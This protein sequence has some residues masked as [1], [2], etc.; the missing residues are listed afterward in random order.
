MMRN[1]SSSLD[2]S[3][4]AARG[5]L[6]ALFRTFD[7]LTPDE[8]ARI[9]YR[10][11]P[12]D[13]RD[14][15]LDAV[16]EAAERTGRVVLVGEARDAAREAVMMRYSAG[17]LHPTFVGLNWGISQGT[18][19]TRVAIAETLADA[20]AAA[21]VADALDPE[22]TDALANDAASIADLAVG[23][24][25]DGSLARALRDPEDSDLRLGP[26]ARRLRLVGAAVMVVASAVASGIG[27]MGAAAV[28]V[29]AGVRALTRGGRRER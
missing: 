15:L 28:G 14:P 27:A 23:E 18:I 24:V 2:P 12:D 22:V 3:D 5:R 11:A 9:G 21:V 1:A 7:R 10:L 17:S 20:A 29:I 26:M 25:S 19:E 4:L 13:A 6:D 16:D 8:L